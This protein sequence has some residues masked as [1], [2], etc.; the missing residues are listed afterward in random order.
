MKRSFSRVWSLAAI[1]LLTL[2]FT[3]DVAAQQTR[4]H[5]GTD[6]PKVRDHRGGDE[7]TLRDHR[8]RTD[9]GRL[10]SLLRADRWRRARDHTWQLIL[11]K[12]DR[13]GD[14]IMKYSENDNFP[15]RDLRLLMD[16]WRQHYGASSGYDDILIPR[17]KDRAVS[18]GI[19]S[20]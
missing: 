6:E 5:R 11:Q 17:F 20:R 1:A 19:W 8:T 18:C 2:A 7:P 13:N 3:G 15:C 9:Y 4:D 16:L 12:G 10:R 14:G